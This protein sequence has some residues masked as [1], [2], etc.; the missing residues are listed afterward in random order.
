MSILK[1]ILKLINS[2][3]DK[4]KYKKAIDKIEGKI[5]AKKTTIKKLKNDSKEVKKNINTRKSKIKKL[6]NTKKKI[7]KEKS[8]D[9]AKDYLDKYLKKRRK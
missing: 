6:K 1:I 3:I 2:I 5:S 7:T 9:D 4:W 8:L